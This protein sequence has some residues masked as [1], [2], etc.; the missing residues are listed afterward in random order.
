MI[1]PKGNTRNESAEKALSTRLFSQ[2][3][4]KQSQIEET[5]RKMIERYNKASEQFDDYLTII[6]PERDHMVDQVRYHPVD[7]GSIQTSI[8]TE[9]NFGRIN[10]AL[11]TELT[12]AEKA[13]AT[14]VEQ[15]RKKYGDS[16]FDWHEDKALNHINYLLAKAI[17]YEKANKEIEKFKWKK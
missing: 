17:A 3:N 16:D 1:S 4:T 11:R 8:K 7:H 12:K 13:Y 9:S 10:K 5:K 2:K 14:K 6:F 15:Y